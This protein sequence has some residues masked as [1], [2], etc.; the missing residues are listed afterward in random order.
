MSPRDAVVIGGDAG[1]AGQLGAVLRALP[2]SVAVAVALS[3]PGPGLADATARARAASRWEVAAAEDGMPLRAGRVVVARP[4]AHVLV[5]EGA[6]RLGAGPRENGFRPAADALFRSAALGLGTRA[7]AILVGEGID[8]PAGLHAVRACGGAALRWRGERDGERLGGLLAGETGEAGE[9]P[10]A[11][12][13]LLRWEMA[14]AGG[15]V[16]ATALHGMSEPAGRPCPACAMPLHRLA[17]ADRF[18]CEA[19]HGFCAE[20]LGVTVAQAERQRRDL[21]TEF[22]HRAR[23]MLALIR[24]VSARTAENSASLDDYAMDFEGR[25]DAIA[26][27]QVLSGQEMRAGTNLEH[28]VA[29]ELVAHLAHEGARV[30]IHGPRV[31]LSF[32]AAQAM[33]LAVHELATH[34]LKFGALSQPAGKLAVSW[35]VEGEGGASPILAFEWAERGVSAPPPSEDGFGMGLLRRML[36]YELRAELSADWRPDAFSCRITLPFPRNVV[37]AAA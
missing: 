24:A 33:A 27:V 21:V 31:T 5:A 30:T 10:G 25:L 32:K 8:G 28:L 17:G 35:A 29:E 16:D 18:R 13:D 11:T 6:V 15:A 36:G 34:A 20:L 7:L 3:A 12:P 19:G 1:A 9:A 37:A 4:G 14:A 23:N 2:P 22:Q 26:R